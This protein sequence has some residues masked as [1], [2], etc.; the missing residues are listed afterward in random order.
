MRILKESFNAG[1]FNPRIQ[2][3]YGIAQYDNGCKTLTN[4]VALPHGPVTRRPGT[5]YVAAVKTAKKYTRLVEFE[6]SQDDAYVLEFGHEYIRFYRNGGQVQTVPAATKLLLHCDGANNATTITDDGNTTHT[7]TAT[8]DAKLKTSQ[9]KFGSASCY[10]DGTGDYLSVPDHA[11]WN[12]GA[13]EFTID[14]WVRFDDVAADQGIFQ[15]W[16]DASNYVSCFWDYSADT[17]EFKYAGAGAGGAVALSGAWEPAANTWYHIAAVRGWGADTD[18]WALCVNGASIDTD[19]DTD[20]WDDLAAAFEIG[21]AEGDTVLLRGYIDEFRVVKGS[22]MW[23]ANFAPPTK[24]YPA[25]DDSGTVY[26]VATTYIEEHLPNLRFAQSADVMYIV[27]EDY[28]VRTLTRTAHAT[29]A[30]ANVTFVPAPAEWSANDYPRTVGFYEDRLCFGGTPDQPDTVW[31]SDTGDYVAFTRSATIT[32]A[33]IAFVNS[34]PDTITDE[35]DGFVA[36]GFQAGADITVSGSALNDGTYTIASVAIGEITLIAKDELSVEAKGESVTIQGGTAADDE[37]INFTLLSR[38]VNDIQWLSSG[39]KL[40]LGTGGDEWWASGPSD[41]EP[42]TPSNKIAKRDSAWGSSRVEPVNVGDVV[43]FVQQGGKTVRELVYDY[44]SDS[45][46]G[47]D[48][49]ILAEHLT[50]DYSITEIAYQ[51]HPYQILWCI[52]SDGS[53]IAMSYM[54]EHEVVAWHL[55][56]TGDGEFESVAVIPGD[57][58]DE[59]WVVVN[60]TVNS[61]VVRYVERM[62]PFSY[63]T[64]LSDAFYV[65]AGLTYDGA[66]ATT[67]SGLSHL[68]GEAVDVLADGAVVTG[69]TVSSGAITLTTAASKVH[70]GLA[71]TPEF[72]TLDVVSSDDEGPLQGTVKRITNVYLRLISSMGGVFGPSSSVTDPITYRVTTAPFTGWLKDLEFNE[73]FDNTSTVYIQCDEPLPFE[74]AAINIDLEDD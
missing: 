67:I 21:M 38:K 57:P 14:F 63:G 49:S 8:G 18:D 41:A 61:A 33:K 27:H 53:M 44:Q 11:D 71:Y 12:F 10:F 66:A 7:V 29:W 45:Y 50:R 68:E 73:D 69:K 60:R 28:V 59:V 9:K 51:H 2:S 39:R 23:E 52:R 64:S 17:L 54:K 37:S 30:I 4:F 58:E 56:T 74:S 22:A 32:G 47:S 72:E 46:V 5:E 43:F 15:Q 35:D 1:G 55:H 42:I 65:D 48:L 36:A 19:T 70:I 24:Q 3:R 16:E 62:K 26:E 6:F 31:L 20:A 13:A 40:L 34:D 25:G